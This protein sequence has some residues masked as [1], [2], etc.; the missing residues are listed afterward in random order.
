MAAIDTSRKVNW[1]RVKWTRAGQLSAIVEGLEGQVQL[2]EL[3]PA[4]AFTSM[5]S[6]NPALATNF[7]AQCLPRMDAVEWLSTCLKRTPA[8]STAELVNAREA[9]V[10]WTRDPS[11]ANR[12]AAF[13][14]G[15]LAGWASAEGAA[16]LAIFLS[17]GSIAPPEQEVPVHPVPG[18]FGLAVAGAVLLAA[19]A[20][21]AEHF[22]AQLANMLDLADD[23][24]SGTPSTQAG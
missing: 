17:G 19:Q 16:C 23:V 10:A 20:S 14:A 18:T 5:R 24:A 22:A 9:V 13:Q 11:E 2:H 12:R 8:A 21:G 15:E 6:L 1:K 4:D 7:I 3:E